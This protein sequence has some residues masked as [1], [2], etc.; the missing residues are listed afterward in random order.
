MAILESRELS[1]PDEAACQQFAEALA[2][3]PGLMDASIELQGGLGAGKTTLV[4]H[5][6]RALGVE[7]RIKS[8]SYAVLESYELPQGVASHF[9][10]YRFDDPREWLDAGFRDVF[11]APGLKLSE[12]PDKAAGMLPVP[13]LAIHMEALDDQS[14]RVRID[15]GTERGRALLAALGPSS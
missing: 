11:V 14:R 1:W 6:L 3:A 4:R 8:P 2:H 5:L 9:D 12:W 13:D 10:F 15:A 7:G